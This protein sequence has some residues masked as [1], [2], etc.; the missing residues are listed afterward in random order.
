MKVTTGLTTE[1]DSCS[2]TVEVVVVLGGGGYDVRI[3]HQEP[4]C[5]PFRRRRD[6]QDAEYALAIVRRAKLQRPS[7]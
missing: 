4:I 7:S 1:C 2:A 3:R 6:A 5:D